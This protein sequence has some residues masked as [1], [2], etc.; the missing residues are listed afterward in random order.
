MATAQTNSAARQS[1]LIDSLRVRYSA[2]VAAG[3]AD[4]KL[5]LFKEAAYL[6]I[7]ADLLDQ[8]APAAA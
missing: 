1:A 2:A 4:A 5:A 6:D 8:P 7:K 3:N